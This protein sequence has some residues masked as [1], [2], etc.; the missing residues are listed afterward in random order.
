ML[1]PFDSPVYYNIHISQ[2]KLRLQM[3][4]NISREIFMYLYQ[5]SMIT[6]YRDSLISLK[7]KTWSVEW[8]WFA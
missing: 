1:P 7:Q 2:T 8:L 4:D 3:I 5:G 6:G